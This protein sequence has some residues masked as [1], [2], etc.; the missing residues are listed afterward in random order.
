M[1]YELARTTTPH[2]PQRTPTHT[3]TT[4]TKDH[5]TSSTITNNKQQTTINIQL[6]TLNR[7]YIYAHFILHP[8]L[9]CKTEAQHVPSLKHR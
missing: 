7:S 6:K 5:H 2:K 4:R 9:V 8:S 3:H 1:L